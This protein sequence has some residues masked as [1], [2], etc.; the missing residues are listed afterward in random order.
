MT[1]LIKPAKVKGRRRKRPNKSMDLLRE[2]AE[3][4]DVYD[5][6]AFVQAYRDMEWDDRSAADFVEAARL[7]LDIGAIPIAQELAMTGV[8]YFPE[9][10]ELQKMAYILAPPKV[11][12]S[13]R[14]PDPAAKGN[15]TWLKK[16]GD[17]YRGKWVALRSGELL[18][19]ADSIDGLVEQV[20]ELKNTGIMVTQVW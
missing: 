19:V 15:M 7:A 20:G 10:P 6:S 12:V 8:Q 17:D 16:H 11:T 18:A 4:S 2:A 1:T 3:A 14:P 13:D 9:H 5:V